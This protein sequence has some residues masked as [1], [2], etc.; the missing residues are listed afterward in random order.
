MQGTL[1]CLFVY[2]DARGIQIETAS[3]Q[4]KVSLIWDLAYIQN[5][6]NVFYTHEMVGWVDS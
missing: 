4:K 1:V 6:F 5:N 3:P 2:V